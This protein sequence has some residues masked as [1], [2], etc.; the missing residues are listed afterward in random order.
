MVVIRLSRGG[1]KKRPFYHI[2]AADRRRSRDG[3]YIEKLGY[4]NPLAAGG[5]T[6]LNIDHDRYQYWEQKGAQP[7]ERVKSLIKDFIAGNTGPDMLTRTEATAKQR[8]QNQTSAAK[9]AKAEAAEPK[10]EAQAAAPEA[11]AKAEAPKAEAKAE[12]PKSEAEAPK[13]EIKS[14]IKLF[15][16]SEGWAPFCSQY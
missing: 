9:K 16:R 1:A 14:L 15:T 12:A 13:A 10:P 4:F 2:V 7:S 8:E 3:R 11:E 6:R 5:E